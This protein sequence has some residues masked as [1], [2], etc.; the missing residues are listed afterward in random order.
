VINA[1]INGGVRTAYKSTRLKFAGSNV[2]VQ[3]AGTT[4]SS[5]L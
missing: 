5:P 4:L 1:N 2:N 3:R